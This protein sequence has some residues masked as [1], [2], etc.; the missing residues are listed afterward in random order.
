MTFN[1]PLAERFSDVPA[2]KLPS[3]TLSLKVNCPLPA[4]PESVALVALSRIYAA[5]GVKIL[6]LGAFAVSSAFE[7]PIPAPPP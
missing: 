5:P 6:R 2:V 7:K 3:V 4:L 1:L